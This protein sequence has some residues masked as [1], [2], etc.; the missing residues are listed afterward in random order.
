[1]GSYVNKN[2]VNGEYVVYTS[3]YH[4]K[5]FFNLKALATLFIAPLIARYSDE[6]AI[7]NK[8]III[9]IGLFSR[10]TLELNLTKVESVLV[11]QTFVGRIFGFGSIIVIGTGGTR[12]TFI[13]L[14]NPTQFKNKFQEIL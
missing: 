13:D 14:K 5:I 12:E 1:M 11:N 2:L 4:W 3:T 9:K 7:T 10:R 6:F 8:R